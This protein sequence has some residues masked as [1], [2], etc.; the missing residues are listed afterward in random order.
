MDEK[1]K[2]IFDLTIQ[3]SGVNQKRNEQQNILRDKRFKFY[4]TTARLRKWI[5]TLAEQEHK[6]MEEREQLLLNLKK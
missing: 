5:K 3:I 4:K 2:P 6:F 1:L